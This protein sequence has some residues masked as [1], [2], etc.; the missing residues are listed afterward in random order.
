M[1]LKYDTFKNRQLGDEL[2]RYV[3]GEVQE[4]PQ[5]IREFDALTREIIRR[6]KEGPEWQ[7]HKVKDRHA[8]KRQSLK[9]GKSAFSANRSCHR[10]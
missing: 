2:L 1:R 4:T 3:N 8:E 5:N 10:R 6:L 7:F 9:E